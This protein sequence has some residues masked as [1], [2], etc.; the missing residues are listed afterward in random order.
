MT[1]ALAVT[2]F[3]LFPPPG[4]RAEPLPD[5]VPQR[6]EE[7][8]VQ[9]ALWLARRCLEAA[10]LGAGPSVGF[11]LV[12]GSAVRAVSLAHART[13]LAGKA[14]SVHQF[15]YTTPN[16]VAPRAAILLGLGGESLTLPDPAAPF[17]A[18]A[19]LLAAGRSATVLAGGVAPGPGGIEG[20]LL[21]LETSGGAAARGVSP[22]GFLSLEG[23][24]TDPLPTPASEAVLSVA[25]AAALLEGRETILDCGPRGR[26]SVQ[27]LPFNPTRRTDAP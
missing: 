21:C 3:A 12:V 23:P 9:A 20:A 4:E 19:D 11:A 14:V 8:A 7:P 22:R 2:G 26:I 6:R 16:T 17:W 15:L 18:A 5:A 10:S 1:P 13:V 27:P 25:A 24:D